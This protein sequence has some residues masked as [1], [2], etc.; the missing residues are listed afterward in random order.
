VA[1]V[2]VVSVLVQLQLLLKLIQLQLVLA[3]LAEQKHTLVEAMEET[4]PQLG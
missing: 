4:L 1:A 3:V 2:A